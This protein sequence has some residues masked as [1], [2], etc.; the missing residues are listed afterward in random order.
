MVKG[1]KATL[2][3]NQLLDLQEKD[4]SKNLSK[5]LDPYWVQVKA[6]S[7]DPQAPKPSLFRVFASKYTSIL[8]PKDLTIVYLRY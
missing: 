5:L 6:R 3:S 8:Y 2:K 7:L 1:A 4:C